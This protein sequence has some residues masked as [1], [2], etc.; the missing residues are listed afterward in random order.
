[1]DTLLTDYGYLGLFVWILLEQA[2]LPIPAVPVLMAA[3][4]LATSGKLAFPPALLACV[5]ACLV[6][7]LLW[8]RVGRSKGVHILHFLCR[9]SWKPNTCI[10]TTKNV[11]VRYGAQTLLFAKFVPGLNTLAPP[12]AGATSVSLRRFLAYDLAGS[13]I[14]C[15]LFLLLGMGLR[16]ALPEPAALLAFLK[17]HAAA[18]IAGALAAF[19]AVRF[20]WRRRYLA[21]L[22]RELR[23]G[24]TVDEL[25]EMIDR[26]DDVVPVDIRHPVNFGLDPHTLPGALRFH[27]AELDARAAEIPLTRPL[28]AFCDCPRDQAAVLAVERLHRLGAASARVLKGGLG[29]WRGRGF[30]VVRAEAPAEASRHSPAP[31]SCSR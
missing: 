24:L 31:A 23:H 6:A 7:D 11:F 26:G 4:T 18:L 17:A 20:A 22:E 29:A 19:L 14:W 10:A 16:A 25:K 27:Y 21:R 2:G 12:L 28:V 30:P 3:G 9:L 13:V 5:A 1:M 8:F 15:G